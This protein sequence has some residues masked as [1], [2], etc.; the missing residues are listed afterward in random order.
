[1]STNKKISVAKYL[2]QMIDISPK[3]QSEITAEIGL[4]KPNIITM[5]K[6]GKTKLP[7]PRVPAMA[8]ALNIDPIYLLQ[9]VMQEYVPETWEV[10]SELLQ[11]KLITQK[12]TAI[13]QMIREAAN[14][15]DL[16]PETSIE[17]EELKRLV[18]KWREREM[19]DAEALKHI[20]EL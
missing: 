1:M 6:Q 15:Y 19:H 20:K 11:N 7:I 17:R 2:A 10:V 8:K 16:A 5:F 4:D 9:L 12:E 3:S 14:G 13:L 18:D